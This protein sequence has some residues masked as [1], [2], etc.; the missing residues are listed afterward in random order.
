MC[1]GTDPCGRG[2]VCVCA[3]ATEGVSKP[4]GAIDLTLQNTVNHV[5]VVVYCRVCVLGGALCD[6][7]H[8]TLLP[9]LQPQCFYWSSVCVSVCEAKLVGLCVH[10]CVSVRER[11]KCCK[12]GG[13]L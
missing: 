5:T 7:R 4:P 11:E 3:E 10:V 1:S 6:R 2:C 13:R 8:V 9:P 12:G